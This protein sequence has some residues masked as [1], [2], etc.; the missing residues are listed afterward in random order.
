VLVRWFL[1]DTRLGELLL[2][3]FE[4]ATGLAVV[5]ADWLGEQRCGMPRTVSGE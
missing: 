4:K 1:F 3:L 2:G 5:H